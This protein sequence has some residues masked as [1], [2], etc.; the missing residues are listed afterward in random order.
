MQAENG[1][2]VGVVER[3]Q[4]LRFAL[5]AGHPLRVGGELG[6]EDLDR[7]LTVDHR[8]V[9]EEPLT[10]QELGDRYHISRERVRQLQEKIIKNLIILSFYI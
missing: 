1:R 8:I 4:Q 5:E 7:H 2:D 3:G 9:A 10:L 6:G